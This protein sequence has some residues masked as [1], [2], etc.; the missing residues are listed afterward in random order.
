MRPS[1]IRSTRAIAR[2]SLAIAIV[3]TSPVAAIAQS[4]KLPPLIDRELFFGDPEISGAQISPDGRF[5]SFLK[6]YKDTR[7]VW[8]K[9]TGD[10]YTSAK[11]ITNDTKRPVTQYF[12]SRDGKYIL[13]VQDQLGDENFNVYAVDPRSAPAAGQDVP[14]ARNI[15]AAKGVRAFIYSVPRN[16]PDIMYV[17]INDRDKAWHDLYRVRISTGERTLMRQNTERIAAWVF[18]NAGALRLALRTSDKGDTEIL[19]VDSAGFTQ[20]YSCTVFESCGPVRFS[21]DNSKIYMETNKGAPDLT[22]LVLFDPVTKTEKVVESDPLNRVD[23]GNASFSD[24]SDE[25]IAT[26]YQD[27]RTRIYWKNKDWEKDYNL[28]KSKLPGKEITPGSTTK[29]ERLW[30]VAANSDREPGER[31]LFDRNS[32][33]L[34][35]QYRI[36][37]KLPREALAQ[38]KPISYKSSDG[39]TIPAY[40]TLPVGVA[41]KNLPLVVYPHGGPWARDSWGYERIAQFLANRGYAVLQPNFRSSTGYGKKFLNAGNLEW[42]QMMQEDLTSGV[43]YL[44]SQGTVDP[45]RVGIM[46]GSYGGYA[47]LAGLAF[48]PDV[49]A[50]GVSIVGPSNLITLLNSIP[51]YWEAGRIIFHERMGNPNTPAGRAQLERQSPLNSASKIKAPL[52]V[53]QGAND[54][55]VNRAESEQLVIALRDR[56]F[57]VEYILAPDE[58]HGF[59]R[60]INNLVLFTTA[61]KFL[62]KHLGGRYQESMTPAISAR[63]AELTVDPKTVKLSRK[64]EVS[65]TAPKPA[66]DLTAGTA[67]YKAR[68]EA[69]GQTIPM[70]LTRTVKDENGSWVVNETS[71]MP[72]GTMSDEAT[73]DKGTLLLRKRVIHQGPAVVDV[74]FADNKATGKI[75]VNGQERPITADLGGALF[76]D[77]PGAS[78]VVA[79]LPLA[80]GYSTTFRNFNLMSQ[81]VKLRQLKVTGSEKV[82]VPAGTFD[83]WKVEITP[84]DGGTGES[85]TLWVDKGSRRVVKVSTIIPEM[86][87][88]TATAELTK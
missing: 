47:T 32:K 14:T 55:R 85:T 7:N 41:A 42:G 4:G 69:G 38:Q 2:W 81:Q 22:A 6:P 43:R 25:L 28:I 18:D 86:N 39:L 17:G 73:I 75:T 29:D 23:F 76:A 82:T 74:S 19:R 20:I 5:I 64:V 87:G 70:D 45:K 66:V 24:V 48:T 50:A 31:Y 11:L 62:A 37:D 30:M 9:R 3:F 57:P 61:E 80:E 34:T 13:F 21:K 59:A 68:L 84:A 77:G 49:Y 33:K 40:L 26:A 16:D 72:M 83:A 1:T 88:A 78:D 67:T 35:F 10:P 54:P 36:F 52:L 56:G 8:V 71:A 79:A 15:T 58:G 27:E 60:P 65:A 53:V 51:P 44:I 12:W 46:G 63:M